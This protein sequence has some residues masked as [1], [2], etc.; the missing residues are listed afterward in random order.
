MS[1]GAPCSNQEFSRSVLGGLFRRGYNIEWCS[2]K[3]HKKRVRVSAQLGTGEIC[4][5]EF[6][7]WRN[8]DI[9][10]VDQ[11]AEALANAFR[12]EGVLASMAG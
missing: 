9:L 6:V 10:S 11:A 4:A 3:I 1:S 2:T 12:R 8:G 7:L 5:A